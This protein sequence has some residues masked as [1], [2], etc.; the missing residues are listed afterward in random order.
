MTNPFSTDFSGA[1]TQSTGNGG[2][3]PA[4]TCAKFILAIRPGGYGPEG[5]FTQGQTGSVYLNTELT[6]TLGKY[7]RRKVFHKIGFQGAPE[8]LAKNGGVDKWAAQGRSFMRAVL[9]SARNINPKDTSAN[10]NA[11]RAVQSFN[12]LNGLEFAAKIGV[13]K[14]ANTKGE[15]DNNIMAVLVPGDKDYE[16][17]MSGNY[18]PGAPA[19]QGGFGAAPTAPAPQWGAPQAQQQ[20]SVPAWQAPQ[21]GGAAGGAPA[22]AN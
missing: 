11:G 7:A 8:S 2:P 9:E 22:W 17:V 20:P 14:Q 5:L 6:I 15:F 10:A 4:G 1:D 21:A 3:I 12:Q 16:A 19:P 13:E 18:V